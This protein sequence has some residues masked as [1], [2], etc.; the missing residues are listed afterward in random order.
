MSE[1]GGG[2]GVMWGGDSSES[3]KPHI[4]SR[5]EERNQVFHFSVCVEFRHQIASL[6]RTD[7]AQIWPRYS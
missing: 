2:M 4:G 3:Y 1:L 5:Q 6:T 7:L